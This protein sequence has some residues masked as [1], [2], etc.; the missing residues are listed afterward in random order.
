MKPPHRHLSLH[1]EQRWNASLPPL[2]RKAANNSFGTKKVLLFPFENKIHITTLNC[3][4]EL[5]KCCFLVTSMYSSL[6]DLLLNKHFRYIAVIGSTKIHGQEQCL[7][8]DLEKPFS[9]YRSQRPRI[10]QH[11][12]PQNWEGFKEGVYLLILSLL[13]PNKGH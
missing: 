13:S 12:Q 4:K 7:A 11:Q 6:W 1:S 5:E 8:S 10:I 2:S 3:T 9:E